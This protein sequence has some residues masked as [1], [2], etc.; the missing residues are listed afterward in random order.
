M[1]NSNAQEPK[2]AASNDKPETPAK[3]YVLKGDFAAGVR[4]SPPAPEGPDFARGV[5]TSPPSPEGPDFARG[6]RTWPMSTD[7]GDFASGEHTWPTEPK[8]PDLSNT[9]PPVP[10]AAEHKA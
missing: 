7:V 3:P 10:V 2:S 9:L 4:T 1:S 5:R 8:N 6:E